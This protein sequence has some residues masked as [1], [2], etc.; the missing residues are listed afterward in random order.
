MHCASSLNHA[1]PQQHSQSGLQT[2][3]RRPHS[4]WVFPHKT[5]RCMSAGARCSWLNPELLHDSH[6]RVIQLLTEVLQVTNYV[7][8]RVAALR[9]EQPGKFT[10]ITA[11]RNNAM[12]HL[13]N[14]FVKGQLHK[15]FF[16][17]PVSLDSPPAV[18]LSSCWVQSRWADSITSD[19]GQQISCGLRCASDGAPQVHRK[20]LSYL[21]R[22]PAVQAFPSANW[23]G[24]LV[25]CFP[26][27]ATMLHAGCAVCITCQHC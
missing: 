25:G 4:R 7:I 21:F 2:C 6:W 5:K 19:M 22:R 9:R 14:Y 26:L 12:R 13:P 11:L 15:L 17:F 1:V 3:Y 20:S 27:I 24:Y 8:E 16:L 23:C 10:N 18:C